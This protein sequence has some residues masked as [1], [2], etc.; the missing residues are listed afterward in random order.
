MGIALHL[1]PPSPTTGTTFNMGLDEQPAGPGVGWMGPKKDRS[2]DVMTLVIEDPCQAVRAA[3]SKPT[4]LSYQ[5]PSESDS[6]HQPQS[7]RW[8][9]SPQLFKER[10]LKGK[11]PVGT[12]ASVDGNVGLDQRR[13]EVTCSRIFG[14]VSV[15][16]APG[17]ARS[18]ALGVTQ[19]EFNSSDSATE[20]G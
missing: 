7:C 11:P 5:K 18:E 3:P 14:L 2:G 9:E 1:V 6:P 15:T 13:I 20:S 17:F 12:C 16:R 19:A 10:L 4:Q 8:S